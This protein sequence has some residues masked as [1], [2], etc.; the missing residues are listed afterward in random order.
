VARS[1]VTH[2][3]TSLVTTLTFLASRNEK[4]VLG[5]GS[6]LN[7]EN[8][9]SVQQRLQFSRIIRRAKISFHG[10]FEYAK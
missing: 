7:L 4:I 3:M 6:D 9:E 8:Y 1:K 2:L 5:A 10:H